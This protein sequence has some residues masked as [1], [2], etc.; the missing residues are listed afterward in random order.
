MLLQLRTEK[1]SAS[2]TGISYPDVTEKTVL[3][4]NFFFNKTNFCILFISL[5]YGAKAAVCSEINTKH[6]NTMWA[7]CT[8][9]EC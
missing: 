4:P 7:E 9:L 1:W 8:F 5:L 3:L 6:I 2:H